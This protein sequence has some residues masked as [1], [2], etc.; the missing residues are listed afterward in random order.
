MKELNDEQR[1]LVEDNIK[2]AYHVAH[3]YSLNVLDEDIFQLACLGLCKAARA[4]DPKKEIQFGT[5]SYYCIE[6]E[7]LMGLRHVRK[8][9]DVASLNAFLY[10]NK[11][12][13]EAEVDLPEMS[14][15]MES[16]VDLS[17]TIDAMK[18]LDARSKEILFMRMCGYTHLEIGDKLHF[19]RS[20]IQRL[21]RRAQAQILQT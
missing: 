4:F 18:S 1:K 13:D 5:F 17:L 9:K 14:C 21:E 10:T 16:T 6:N 7:I 19:S 2:L 11:N 8:H 20:Y 12:G 3:R 15:N